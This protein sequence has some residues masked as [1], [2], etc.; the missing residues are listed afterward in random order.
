MEYDRVERSHIVPRGYLHA[1]TDGKRIAMRRV[2][3]A[4]SVDGRGRGAATAN[5]FVV[6]NADQQWFHRPGVRPWLPRGP[7]AS[8]SADILASYDPAAAAGSRR[9]ARATQIAVEIAA[10]PLD[11]HDVPVVTVRQVPDDACRSACAT[12]RAPKTRTESS[13]RVTI[14]GVRQHSPGYVRDR[15][16]CYAGAFGNRRRSTPFPHEDC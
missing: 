9:R 12:R 16:P 14:W 7:R 3:A 10:A 5:A 6:A 8:L 13:L 1:W 2:G 4:A 11:N 15:S